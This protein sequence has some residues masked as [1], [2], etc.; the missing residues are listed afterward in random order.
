[1]AHKRQL[2]L[3]GAF[4]DSLSPRGRTCFKPETIQ[5]AMEL[6]PMRESCRPPRGS[7]EIKVRGAQLSIDMLEARGTRSSMAMIYFYFLFFSF[8][9]PLPTQSELLFPLSGGRRGTHPPK[10]GVSGWGGKNSMFFL[11][12]SFFPPRS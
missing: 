1:M 8:L 7:R 6:T 4:W 9:V 11:F 10:K 5:T 2:N 3:T 12:F